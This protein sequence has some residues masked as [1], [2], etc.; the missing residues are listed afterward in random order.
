M[1][2]K[3]FF[4]CSIIYIGVVGIVAFMQESGSYS[5]NLFGFSLTLPIAVWIALAV[6]V[7]AVLAILHLMAC[8]ISYYN[9]KRAISKD[10]NEYD[11]MSKE[12]LL[13]LES[14]KFFKTEYF[15]EASEVTKCLSPWGLQ[16]NESSIKNEELKGIFELVKS[17]KNGE[18]AELK[19]FKLPKTNPLFVLNEL[20]K[21]AKI[22]N[23]PLK[24]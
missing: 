23:M 6:A 10:L 19:K 16:G 13:G 5:L 1:K 15:K 7:Y 24:F 17:I 12:I 11:S 9:A 8:G 21:L 22:E 4:V 20:N 18:V 14:N 2:I 3:Q